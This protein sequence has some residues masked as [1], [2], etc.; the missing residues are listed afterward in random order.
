M[1]DLVDFKIEI[2]ASTLNVPEFKAIWKRD[3]Q[4]TKLNA[5]AELC[6]VFY[7]CDYKS[8]YRNYPV[9]EKQAK[10][11]KD[12]TDQR[13]GEKWKPDAKVEAA[14]SKY[15][16]MQETH[17]LRFLIGVQKTLDKLSDYLDEVEIEDGKDGNIT[18]IMAA[19]DKGSKIVA[20]LA[21]LKESV[22]KEVSHIKKYV[23]ALI[24]K[25]SQNFTM[26]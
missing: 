16:E 14:I 6:Y 4:R 18:Q 21:K 2:A 13:L 9:K 3:K 5:Y 22:S 10:I 24:V 1:F 7:M 20:G 17:S 25:V 26:G 23:I 15:L 19:I 8:E 12:F 11:K